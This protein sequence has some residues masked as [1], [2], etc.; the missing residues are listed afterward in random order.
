MA[1]FNSRSNNLEYSYRI[2][3]ATFT[4][5]QTRDVSLQREYFNIK[6]RNIKTSCPKGQFAL[7]ILP[8]QLSTAASSSYPKREATGAYIVIDLSALNQ[9]VI[10]EHFQVENIS[11]LKQILN[12]HD[13]MV[14]LGL[15]DAYLTVGVHARAISTSNWMFV[16]LNKSYLPNSLMHIFIK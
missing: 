2:S 7:S 9:F 8:T 5:S 6:R 4:N 1:N 10:N 12:Q 3:H 16:K 11:C 13:F 15:K 14:K